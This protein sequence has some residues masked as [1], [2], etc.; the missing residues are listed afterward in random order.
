MWVPKLNW[1]K[2]LTSN[3]GGPHLAPVKSVQYANLSMRWSILSSIQRLKMLLSPSWLNK[4]QGCPAQKRGPTVCQSSYFYKFLTLHL[5]N[6]YILN[7]LPHEINVVQW[8]C[9]RA[10]LL[11]HIFKGV[12]QE[13]RLICRWEN[14]SPL[15]TRSS[16]HF[17]HHLLAPLD[18][19]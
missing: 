14:T 8:K 19:I 9:S 11:L 2:S 7:R 3:P 16:S 5:M 1:I 4:T 15:R 13:D 6:G 12:F 10:V 17:A 18:Q